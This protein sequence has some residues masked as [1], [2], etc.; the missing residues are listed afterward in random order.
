M[1]NKEVNPIDTYFLDIRKQLE[2]IQTTQIDLNDSFDNFM[3]E[4]M[5][6]GF[7]WF[8]LRQIDFSKPCTCKQATN[9]STAQCKRCFRI[10]FLFTDYIVKGYMW[11]S[12][13]GFEFRTSTGDISTQRRNLV[14]QHD[15]PVNKFD[16]VLVLD[17]ESETGKIMQPFKVMREF[18]VQDSLSLRG[19]NGR[20]EYWRCS[21]EERN[22]DDGR[23]AGQGVEFEYKG[24]RSNAEPQ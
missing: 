19:K 12:A 21:L 2:Q 16:K 23:F 20:I 5:E 14:L 9:Q 10:G 1:H 4:M 15:R 6:N 18:S 3:R 8:G 7:Q 13:M 22:L 24:N 17:I 11:L